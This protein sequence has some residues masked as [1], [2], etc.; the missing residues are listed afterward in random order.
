MAQ[1]CVRP[2]RQQ[3]RTLPHARRHNG[4]QAINAAKNDV[5]A[6]IADATVDG[7]LADSERGDLLP[8]HN[9]VLAARDSLNEDIGVRGRKHAR[10]CAGFLGQGNAQSW[11]CRRRDG[12][13]TA[14]TRITN[15][16]WGNPA[17]VAVVNWPK[18]RSIAICGSITDADRRQSTKPNHWYRLGSVPTPHQQFPRTQR[19]P[20]QPAL[21]ASLLRG[22]DVELAAALLEFI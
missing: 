14:P 13:V 6:A 4:S 17:S 11:R 7:T 19:S 9:A 22:D 18:L 16:G 3:R 5:K 1:H 21:E 20:P 15:L 2:A 12:V 8:S 10:K